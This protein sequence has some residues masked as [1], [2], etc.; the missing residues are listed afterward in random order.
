VKELIMSKGYGVKLD[1]ELIRLIDLERQRIAA[2]EFL[3]PSRTAVIKR[4]AKRAD[5]QATTVSGK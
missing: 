4:W 1:S 3:V 2:T 5:A